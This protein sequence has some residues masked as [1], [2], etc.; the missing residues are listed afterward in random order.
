MDIPPC[1]WVGFNV[2]KRIINYY[3]L[4]CNEFKMK[5]YIEQNIAAAARRVDIKD[6]TCYLG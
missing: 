6:N 4:F 2:V 5:Y 3:L 1:N